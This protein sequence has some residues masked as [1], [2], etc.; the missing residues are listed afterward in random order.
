MSTILV[1]VEQDD[2]LIKYLPIIKKNTNQSFSEIRSSINAGTPIMK[3][4]LFRDEAEDKKLKLL[5]DELDKL[6]ARLKL[7]EDQ[8]DK[9]SEVPMD[10]LLNR[11]NR[12]SEIQKQNKRL[13]DLMYG[14]DE[15]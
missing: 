6:G 7:F 1:L 12:F 8:V 9:N 4:I 14:E 10:Y 2:N 13:D 3:C 15:N 11:F 5:I